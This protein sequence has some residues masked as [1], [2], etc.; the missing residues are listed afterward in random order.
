MNRERD[1]FSGEKKSRSTLLI[2]RKGLLDFQ[3]IRLFG[4]LPVLDNIICAALRLK[5]DPFTR[6]FACPVCSGKEK[7]IYE[8]SL[9]LLEAVGL[10]PASKNGPTA[11]L[12]QQRRRKSPVRKHPT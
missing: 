2:T 10:Q 9:R 3:N 5:S 6:S 8:D 11:A 4:S 7:A 1:I 12:R